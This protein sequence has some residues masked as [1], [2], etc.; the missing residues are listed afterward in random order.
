MLGNRR[1]AGI[2]ENF[3]IIGVLAFQHMRIPC[4]DRLYEIRSGRTAWL[5]QAVAPTL[6]VQDQ[7]GRG[8]LADVN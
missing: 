7:A 4:R 2:T 5:I 6:I 3:K 1:E 8:Q